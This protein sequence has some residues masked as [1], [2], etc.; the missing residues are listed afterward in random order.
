M[1]PAPLVFMFS[2]QGSQ[3]YQMGRPLYE[4]HALFREWM[5]ELDATVERRLGHSVTDIIYAPSKRLSDPFD[6]TRITHPALFMVQFALAQLL[7][8]EGVRP[9]HLL[10]VSLGEFVAAA[11]AGVLPVEEALDLVIHQAM[12]IEARCPAGRMLAVA[13]DTTLYRREPRLHRQS[14]LAGVYAQDHFVLSGSPGAIEEIRNW[15]GS[16]GI[17]HLQLP[18]THGFH[19]F[20]MEPARAEVL[21]RLQTKIYQRPRLPWISCTAGQM[22]DADGSVR[23]PHAYAVESPDAAHFW[24]AVRQPICYRDAIRSEFAGTPQAQYVDLGPWSSLA[25]HVRKNLDDGAHG[26]IYPI[27]TPWGTDLRNLERVLAEQRT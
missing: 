14:E 1:S 13:H 11:V 19:A 12:T 5:H 20:L 9:T 8:A 10:G 6:A 15:L 22:P 16:Q 3:A 26:Q 2:G 23:L 18:I 21:A 4:G 27:M 24:D 17:V 25:N 7:L